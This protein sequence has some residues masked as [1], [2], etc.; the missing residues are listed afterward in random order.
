MNLK[1][2]VIVLLSLLS[3]AVAASG[4]YF[5]T[6][7]KVEDLRVKAVD[8]D[9]ALETLKVHDAANHEATAVLDQKL[10]SVISTLD[11]IEKKLP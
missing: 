11:R 6:A 7:S 4:A 2:P 9:K 8:H 3:S 5:V 1:L 10:D